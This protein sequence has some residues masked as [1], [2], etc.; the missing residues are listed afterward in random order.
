M[1][2]TEHIRQHALEHASEADPMRY[3]NLVDSEWSAEFEALMRN[4][5]IMGALRYGL[6]SDPAKVKN[7]E[8]SGPN[9]RA[10][11]EL[12]EATGNTEWLVDIAN[13]ALLEFV[14]GNHP[15]KHFHAHCR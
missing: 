12:Y 14:E 4:R 5:L 1:T 3:E 6:I 11:L 9:I 13:L 10:R 7:R 15:L 2:V 8:P